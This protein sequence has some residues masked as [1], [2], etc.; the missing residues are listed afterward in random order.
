FNTAEGSRGR[1]REA[2][3]P[4]LFDRLG[5]PFTGSDAYVCAL[6]LDKQLTKMVVAEQGV[7][8]P[9]GM[10]ITD[11]GQL[12]G[13]P[14][15]FPVIIK[16]NFEGSSI[17]ITA[18]SVVESP[19]ALKTR[20]VELL[21]RF[22]AGLLVEEFIV[23]RD[24]VVPFVEKASPAT[25]GVLEPA[26]YEYTSGKA[27]KYQIYDYDLKNAASDSVKVKIPADIPE[28]ARSGI[29]ELSQRVFRVLGVRDVG[30]I[31]FR[32]DDEG[33]LYFI[34]INA[35]P[36]L[37]EGASIYASA[38][39]AGL[40]KME[41]VL[42]A[43]V[44]SAAERFHLSLR[45]PRASRRSGSHLRV[46]LTFNLRRTEKLTQG[47]DFDAEYDSPKT[48]KAI[49]EAIES[50]GHNV[51]EF[52][53]T[54]ELPS[55][56]SAA[57]VDLVFNVA[58]G[59]KGRHR[60]SQIPAL[61]ELLGIPYTGSDPTAL[62]LSLDKGLAKRLVRQA[63]FHT[64][65][66]VLMTTGKERLPKDLS[67]PAIVKPVAEGSSKGILQTSVVESEGELRELAAQTAGHYRQAVI[68][69]NFVGGRE[70]TV[71]LLGE[72]RPKALPPMEIVFESGQ[73]KYPVYSFSSKFETATV[74]YEVPA[75]VDPALDAELRRVA[76]GVFAVLGCRDV[77]RVDLRLDDRGQVHFIEC[78]PLPGL[79]PGFSD[80][81]FIAEA[82]G[83]D[84][85]TLIGEILAPC[86]R[87]WREL[88]KERRIGIGVQ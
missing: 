4:A 23:G 12:D 3:Y 18:D 25:G 48:I 56:L 80:F 22:P 64:P 85:R 71:G 58:E 33:K 68:A 10:F 41:D 11:V 53:A 57:D 78:N 38:A 63:G 51:V 1:F 49:R 45:P 28:Q 50:Y 40:T 60:E 34:E 77:S 67:F 26:G 15:R 75:K 6:T 37:E 46:G 69:E 42:G 81:C 5:I 32:I 14:F 72:K 30:R 73:E 20:T 13:N 39:R 84:Y 66:F 43:V 83:L 76:R 36:S 59:F 44:E 87:R 74:R 62:S 9:R 31:D 47:N 52:E 54:P 65:P 35:L 79:S 70:F 7:P 16:P 19:R 17:G 21:A 27:S 2:F 55:L 24:I 61:L 29:L 82:A 86:I 8:A 88:Q